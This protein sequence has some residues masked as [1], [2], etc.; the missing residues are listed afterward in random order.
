MELYG[1][2]NEYGE[3]KNWASN[4]FTRFNSWTSLALYAAGV[5]ILADD[6]LHPEARS[7]LYWRR[8]MAATCMW[9]GIASFLFHASLTEKWRM[10]SAGATMGTMCVPIVYCAYRARQRCGRPPPPTFAFVGVVA[11]FVFVHVLARQPGWSTGVLAGGIAGT[12]LVDFIVLGRR[13]KSA[14]EWKACGCFVATALLGAFVRALDIK[15]HATDPSGLVWLGHSLWH[16]LIS[17]A[18]LIA[19]DGLYLRFRPPKAEEEEPLKTE[20]EEPPKAEAEETEEQIIK[21]VD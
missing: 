14:R 15:L 7:V 9:A 10:L 16:L 11:V 19:Y 8:A 4:I 13:E 6:M 18:V 2:L 20:A 3:R 5:V 12:I 17:A 21:Q 1:E